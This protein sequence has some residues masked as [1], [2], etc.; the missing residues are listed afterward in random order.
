MG[1]L[2]E[3][4]QSWGHRAGPP[5]GPWGVRARH[6]AR[7]EPVGCPGGAEL[8]LSKPCRRRSPG[9]ATRGSARL[10]TARPGSRRGQLCLRTHGTLGLMLE[11]KMFQA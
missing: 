9:S 11:G 7:G 10:G 4:G 6:V 1:V 5:H 3:D 2:L 8:L